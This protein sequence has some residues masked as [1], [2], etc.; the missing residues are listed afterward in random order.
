MIG[1]KNGFHFLSGCLNNK[2]KQT[3][4][5]IL[6]KYYSTSKIICKFTDI[7]LNCSFC[8]S[9]TENIIHLCF[10]FPNSSK[11]WKESY[12]SHKQNDHTLHS[13]T[14]TS[15]KSSTICFIGGKKA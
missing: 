5:K 2:N 3:N 9:A 7:N 1:G 14:K 4:F 13:K 10:T 8:A 12:L 15:Q 6:H 11:F